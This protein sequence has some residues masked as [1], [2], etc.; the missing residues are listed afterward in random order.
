[1]EDTQEI[2]LPYTKATPKR[3]CNKVLDFADFRSEF[4]IC[5]TVGFR[6]TDRKRRRVNLTIKM[7]ILLQNCD[8]SKS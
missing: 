2:K 5:H 6:V 8:N 7:L 1:M 3:Y 4:L